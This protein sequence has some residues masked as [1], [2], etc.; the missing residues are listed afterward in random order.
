M[1]QYVLTSSNVKNK[2][3]KISL[4]CKM[5]LLHTFKSTT[6]NNSLLQTQPVKT[7]N[8]NFFSE[9]CQIYYHIT[10][11]ISE[12]QFCKDTIFHPRSKVAIIK[13]KNSKNNLLWLTCT[14]SQTLFSPLFYCER[15]LHF[16]ILY[17]M[18]KTLNPAQL[19]LGKYKGLSAHLLSSETTSSEQFCITPHLL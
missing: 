13:C 14:W 12:V 8:L 6:S 7:I 11:K 1:K 5:S 16:I 17:T 15:H 19:L 3:T 4:I 18:I 2:A 10:S 9:Q